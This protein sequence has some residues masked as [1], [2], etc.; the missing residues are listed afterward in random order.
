MK[1]SGKIYQFSILL[2]LGMTIMACQKVK[3][4]FAYPK[5]QVAIIGNNGLVIRDDK[6]WFADLLGGQIIAA[7]INSGK[8]FATYTQHL[9]KDAPDD[10]CFIDDENFVWTSPFSGTVSKTN[11]DGTT[12]QLADVG[13]NVNP[14]AKIPNEHAVAVSFSV[15]DK[16]CIL[17]INTDNGKIDTL[18]RDAVPING[19]DISST[20]VVY[21]PTNDLNSILG[22]GNLLRADLNSGIFTIVGLHFPAEPSKP[23]LSYPTGVA[24]GP[25]GSVYMLQSLPPVSVYK[26]DPASGTATKLASIVNLIGDNIYV[27]Y[28]GKAYVSTFIGNQ[29]IEIDSSGHQRTISIQN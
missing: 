23:G 14:V 22:K 5:E 15:G 16:V 10:L 19:F 11:I 8:I 28:D 27:N 13:K 7:D 29:I 21:A 1:M 4:A 12:I 20:N 25:G 3:V 17:K 24:L 6:I 26:V 18:V 9:L 2:L